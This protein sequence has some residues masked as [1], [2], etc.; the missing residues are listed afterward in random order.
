MA[1]KKKS[2]KKKNAAPPPVERSPFWQL[3]GAILLC[4]T[5]IFLLLGGFGTGGALPVNLFNGAYAVF[6]WAAYL[7][8]VA[9]VYW[10]IYKFMSDD[11]RIPLP[12][13]LGIFAVLVFAASWLFTAFATQQPDGS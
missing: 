3:T 2:T 4:L 9:L 8:P 6:G 10:G 12:K 13:L 11:R 5:A 1:K 7:A